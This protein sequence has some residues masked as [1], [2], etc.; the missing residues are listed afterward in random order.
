MRVTHRSDKTVGSI[1]CLSRIDIIKHCCARLVC[2]L[3]YT[4]IRA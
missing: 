1:L 4:R 3:A 2:Q